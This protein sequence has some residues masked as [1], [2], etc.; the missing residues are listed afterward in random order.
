M[1]HQDAVVVDKIPLLTVDTP[2]GRELSERYRGRARFVHGLMADDIRGPHFG[3]CSSSCANT[4]LCVNVYF[5]EELERCFG[6]DI[7]LLLAGNIE[8]REEQAVMVINPAHPDSPFP[9]VLL[10][11]HFHDRLS[12]GRKQGLVVTL[13]ELPQARA[14]VA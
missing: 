12:T 11:F 2:A 14:F 7:P 4:A 13:D 6:R 3:T 9:A 1:S 5:H 10:R 8:D